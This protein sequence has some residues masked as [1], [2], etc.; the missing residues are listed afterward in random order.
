[1]ILVKELINAIREIATEEVI[2][3]VISNKMNKEME[4]NKINI[5]LKKIIRKKNI[6]K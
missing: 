4:Y 5:A 1:M 3:V 6:I 2:K